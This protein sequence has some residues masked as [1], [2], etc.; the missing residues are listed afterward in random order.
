MKIC[1]GCNESKEDSEYSYRDKAK[2]ERIR[3]CKSCISVLTKRHY[4]THKP[5]YKETFGRTRARKQLEIQ[6]LKE[7]SPCKDCN[8]FYPYYVMDYDHRNGTQKIGNVSHLIRMSSGQLVHDEIQKCDLVCAN[9]H[10]IRTFNRK[11]LS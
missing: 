10:R 5:I 7:A 6:K 11:T 3:Q 8:Q 4:N 9:C 2:G 1:S